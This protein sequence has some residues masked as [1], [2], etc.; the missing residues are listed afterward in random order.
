[1]KL[2][3]KQM[4]KFYIVNDKFKYLSHHGIEGQKHGV[5]NGPPY[6]LSAKTFSKAEK[7][8]GAVVSRWASKSKKEKE[9]AD[10]M[11]KNAKNDKQLHKGMYKKLVANSW[12]AAANK[13]NDMENPYIRKANETKKEQKKRIQDGAMLFDDIQTHYAST[14]YL[15]FVNQGAD[16][17]R[18]ARLFKDYANVYMKQ[19][20]DAFIEEIKKR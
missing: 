16:Y 2:S 14:S 19:P 11:I 5:R 8:A 7:R 13:L 17:M 1:M 4:N 12:E 10:S 9:E 20:A 18:N 3:K 6:P 15:T